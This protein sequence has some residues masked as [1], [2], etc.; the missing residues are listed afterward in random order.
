MKS[1]KLNKGIV[2]NIIIVI[3]VVYISTLREKQ[4]EAVEVP[5]NENKFFIDSPIEKKRFDSII[6]RDSITERE[7]IKIIPVENPLNDSLLANYKQAMK[8]NDS[9]KQLALY[10]EAITERI[11]EERFED[12]IQTI[13]VETEVVGTMKSQFVKYNTRPKTIIV[14][15]EEIKK[16]SLY[17][18]GFVSDIN[19]PALGLNL[20]LLN[21]EKNKIFT[22]GFDTEKR[23]H[24]G[25]TFKIY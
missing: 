18:G 11:Y 21:R 10:K 9:L 19:E 13:I 8:E 15:H 22:I 25:A 20:N 1:L 4:Q 24:I 12:T 16:I 5:A 7:I 17:A 6:Y 23:L 2:Y 3:L 14:E